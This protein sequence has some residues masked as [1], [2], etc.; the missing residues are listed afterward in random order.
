ME[1]LKK[2]NNLFVLLISEMICFFIVKITLFL[3][4]NN[5]IY[6][7]GINIVE[8]LYFFPIFV[9]GLYLFYS[10]HSNRLKLILSSIGFILYSIFLH[11]FIRQIIE[12]FVS[13]LGT[14]NFVVYAFKIY[15]ICLPLVGFRILATKKENTQNVYFLVFIRIIL[16]LFFSL[17]FKKF[18]ALKGILYSWPL[19]EFILFFWSFVKLIKQ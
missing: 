9:F 6:S 8:L 10:K 19:H 12:L 2:K 1:N 4:E 18:F 16:L 15:F 13:S 11:F 17:L 3:G 7:F 5:S 14:I